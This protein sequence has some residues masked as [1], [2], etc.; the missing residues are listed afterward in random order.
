MADPVE[1]VLVVFGVIG[2]YGVGCTSTFDSKARALVVGPGVL[3]PPCDPEEGAGLRDEFIFPGGSVVLP[4]GTVAVHVGWRRSDRA[5][6]LIVNMGK[7]VDDITF[8]I[9]HTVYQYGSC[10]DAKKNQAYMAHTLRHFRLSK[11]ELRQWAGTSW[12]TPPTDME[13]FRG[14]DAVVHIQTDYPESVRL[15]LEREHMA[16]EARRA[17]KNLLRVPV[18]DWTDLNMRQIL[19]NIALSDPELEV[20]ESLIG[21]P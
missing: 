11:K 1:D 8:S 5:A 4:P 16:T 15:S 6:A 14:P 2:S 10:W 17:L 9:A 7:G 19:L 21:L 13:Q 12:G 18:A 20:P 3:R